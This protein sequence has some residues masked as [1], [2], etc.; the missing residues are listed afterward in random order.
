[1]ADNHSSNETN[2]S[3]TLSNSGSTIA[4]TTSATCVYRRRQRRGRNP[5]VDTSNSSSFEE[6]IEDSNQNLG[7]GSSLR[8]RSKGRE[9]PLSDGDVGSC[10]STT[11]ETNGNVKQKKYSLNHWKR[12]KGS[13]S[14]S[15][16]LRK[17]CCSFRGFCNCCR[18]KK[19]GK[20]SGSETHQM[21]RAERDQK[22]FETVRARMRAWGERSTFH[23]VD[24]LMDTPADWRRVFVFLLLCVMTALCWLCC[25]KM[26]LGF[27]NKSITTVI[28]RD[29][30]EFRFPAITVC[31]DSPFTMKDVEDE[32]AAFSK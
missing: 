13:S 18:K 22:K 27:L 29:M 5:I 19:E 16:K 12:R 3:S 26:V 21:S 20:D 17:R 10:A 24:V 32:G 1:M 6:S 4:D 2:C 30:R 11:V 31:P 15:G 23:G 9:K 25:G 8:K 28:D 7:F 14:E